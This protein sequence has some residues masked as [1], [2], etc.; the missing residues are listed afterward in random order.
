MIFIAEIGL[1]HNGNFDLVYE[2]VKQA[3]YADANIVKFQLGW[4]GNPGELNYIDKNIMEKI[5]ITCEY[6]EIDLMFSVFTNEAFELLKCFSPKYYKIASRTLKDNLELVEKIIAQDTETI[7]SLGMWD[8]DELPF[9]KTNKLK[10]LWC[11][12]IYPCYP[13]DMKDFPKDFS[14]TDYDGYSD[15]SI[16]IEMC[17]LAIARGAQIVEKHL[18]LDKSDTTIRDHALSSTPEELRQLVSIGRDIH[19]KIVMGV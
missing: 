3:R 17:L 9:R 19:K 5:I 2:L 15:H 10:Y 14:G 18:T 13:W 6:F 7:I 16:G 12:S 11:K 4:R 1:N 8:N